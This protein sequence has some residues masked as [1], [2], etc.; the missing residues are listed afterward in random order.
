MMGLVEHRVTMMMR[1]FEELED[2]SLYLILTVKKVSRLHAIE[3]ILYFPTVLVTQ[4]H[5]KRH[6]KNEIW[7]T[8]LY[9]PLTRIE[10]TF[11]LQTDKWT[12]MKRSFHSGR[13]YRG[14]NLSNFIRTEEK[15]KIISM[16][17]KNIFL[18]LFVG[19]KNSRI[20]HEQ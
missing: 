2:T 13:R 15:E 4:P 11:P 7:K 12:T 3:R 6:M 17:V 8:K 1:H 19:M 14:R 20:I 5:R 9:H 16:E 18:C 10:R